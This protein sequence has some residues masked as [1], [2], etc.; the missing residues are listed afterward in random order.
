MVAENINIF[1]IALHKALIKKL[2]EL[3][4]KDKWKYTFIKNA[5]EKFSCPVQYHQLKKF[6]NG[7][8]SNENIINVMML[9]ILSIDNKFTLDVITEKKITIR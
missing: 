2:I 4:K 9:E 3:Y 7:N 1:R 8:S 6:E 5:K